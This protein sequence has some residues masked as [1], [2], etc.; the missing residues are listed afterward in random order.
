MVGKKK[1]AKVKEQKLELAS[2]RGRAAAVNDEEERVQ[3]VKD[4]RKMNWKRQRKKEKLQSI[5]GHCCL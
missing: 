5:K 2:Q 1:K 3:R 4:E